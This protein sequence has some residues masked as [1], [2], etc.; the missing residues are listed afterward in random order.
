ML[1]SKGPDVSF[2]SEPPPVVW[3]DP[4]PPAEGSFPF[5]SSVALRLM[6]AFVDTLG[7]ITT[8]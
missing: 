2:F 4:E 1:L 6:L 3:F 5:V 8:K 7:L